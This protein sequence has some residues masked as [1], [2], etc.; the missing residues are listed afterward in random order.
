MSALAEDAPPSIAGC[1]SLPANN[2]WNA[3]VDILPVH[4]RSEEYISSLGRDTGLKMDFGS[5][6]W[7]EKPIGMSYT[8]VPGTQPKVPIEFMG[9]SG[10]PGYGKESDP[11]PYPIPPDAPIQGGLN[12][13]GDRHVLVLDRDTCFLYELY[14]AYPQPDGSWIAMGG[15]VFNL[16][17]NDLRPTG[18]TSTDLAGL[19]ILPGLVRY[20]DVAAG[21]INHALR[22]TAQATQRAYIWPARN[23]HSG[24]SI[25]PSLP[26]LGTRVRL[27]ASV[28]ISRFTPS[29]RVILQ[30]LK[31]YGM[32]LADHGADWYVSG[33]PDPHWSN[34]RLRQMLN[35]IHGSDFEVVDVSSLLVDSNSGLA[36]SRR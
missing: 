31:T 34:P 14:R 24:D 18:W 10:E 12:S 22:Y 4:S 2:I 11:G 29:N 26:P 9:I 30:A 8:T 20:E 6:Y 1:P 13:A 36:A 5:R 17:S 27:K 7:N 16:R 33:V 25:S 3:R 23:L 21:R 19:P 28:D 35:H 32:I 15:A